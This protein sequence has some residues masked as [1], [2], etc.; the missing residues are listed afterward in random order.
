MAGTT[1]GLA[2]FDGNRYGNLGIMTLRQVNGLCFQGVWI[3]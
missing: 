2:G 3:G 1:A